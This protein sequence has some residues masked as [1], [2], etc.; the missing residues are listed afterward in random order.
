LH[1]LQA[2]QDHQWSYTAW[3][4]HPRAGPT[5]IS[6]WNYTPSPR[7]G[8]FVKQM[9]DGTLPPY[10]PPMETNSSANNFPQSRGATNGN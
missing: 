8:I 9:L 5:L 6:N 2:I 10:T 1:V 4:L 7:F 3:D